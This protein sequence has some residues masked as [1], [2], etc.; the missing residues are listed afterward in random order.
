MASSQNYYKVLQVETNADLDTIKQA[1]RKK[2]RIYHPDQF[3]AELSQIKQSGNAPAVKKLEQKIHNA[4]Q[5]TQKINE[6]YAV[7]SDETDRVAYDRYLSNERQRQYQDEIRQQRMRHRG[8]GR[9]TVKSRPHSQNPFFRKN[10]NRDERVPWALLLG[11]ITIFVV[12]SITF[13]NMINRMYSPF[14]TYIPRDSASQ[15]SIAVID[16]Q[17]TSNAE[18]AT[19][20]A[21][22]TIVFEPS[23]TP[24]SSSDN[25]ILGDRYMSFDLFP[26]AIIAYSDAIL[27]DS[28]NA[29]IYVKRAIAY[30]GLYEDGDSDALSLALAD[31]SEAIN[32]DGNLADAYLS[33]GILYY[34]LWLVQG[35]FAEEARSDLEQ[36]LALAPQSNP[37]TVQNILAELP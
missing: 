35:N 18:Q 36:Y 11:M 3:A 2:I 1:Y 9:R 14:T 32:L 4:K 22:R 37:E 25:E 10:P 33:R 19:Y 29:L 17:A 5:M 26:R 28:D 21:R 34:E 7:L 20:I 12:A 27:A 23:A 24:R 16:L 31:Y 30:T 13:S 15:G 8:V 6:A